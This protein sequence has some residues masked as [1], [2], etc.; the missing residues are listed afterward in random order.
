MAMKLGKHQSQPNIIGSALKNAREL[1]KLDRAELANLCCLSPKMVLELEEG[2]L[3]SFYTFQLK[4]SSA[5]RVGSF[6]GLVESSYL[7]YPE[8]LET[9]KVAPTALVEVVEISEPENLVK[10]ESEIELKK[11]A[12]KSVDYVSEK[13]SVNLQESS[14]PQN[15]DLEE[16]LD[17][18]IENRGAEFSSSM[19]SNLLR[20]AAPLL[21]GFSVLAIAIVGLNGR[22]NLR[23]SL[24]DLVG[25][26]APLAENT[27]LNVKTEVEL[28]PAPTNSESSLTVPELKSGQ[29]AISP[30][31]EQCPYKQEAQP[32]NYQSSNP[33][34]P[35]NVVNIKS[36]TKQIICI[37]DSSGK[38]AVINLESNASNVFRGTA[39]FV[40]L[41]QDLD[42][43]EM[44]F[45]GWRV[46]A[47]N[48]G[49]KQIKLLEVP[50]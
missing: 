27:A 48:P 32:I 42:N 31:V 22:F 24:F 36:L 4:V 43:V 41:T 38:Q 2:G 18:T 47:P 37:V 9:L 16:K 20:T 23:S 6:L 45:Q 25:S 46:R 39:P 34:K 40:V 1:K 10:S 30:P 3:S 13:N 8:S 29:L 5:K 15:L 28:S 44:Y 14:V 21:F 7:A 26:P 49:V 35:G 33:S 17:E 12:K 50:M 19:P 11:P